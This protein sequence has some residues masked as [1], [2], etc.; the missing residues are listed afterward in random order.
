MTDKI[1]IIVPTYNRRELLRA[2]LESFEQLVCSCEFEIIV[3]DDGSTDD[4][5]KMVDG[6]I[7]SNPGLNLTYQYLEE[8][9]GPSHARN[10]G[11]SISSGNLLAF[12]DSDCRVDSLWAEQLYHFLQKNPSLGGVGGKVLP[13][14][15][16]IISR[17]YTMHKLLE[18]PHSMINLIGA[19]CMFWKQIVVLAG[20]FDESFVIPGGEEVCLC[21]KILAMGYHFGFEERAIVFHDYRKELRDFV[22]TFFNYGSG[23]RNIIERYFPLYLKFVNPPERLK[24]NIALQNHKAFLFYFFKHQLSTVIF[25]ERP[26]LKR[27]QLSLKDY[28]AFQTL[29]I[30]VNISFHLGRGTITGVFRKRFDRYVTENCID[31]PDRVNPADFIRKLR[32]SRDNIRTILSPGESMKA[33]VSFVNF[34]D[35]FYMPRGKIKIFID[36]NSPNFSISEIHLPE[37]LIFYPKMEYTCFFTLKTATIEGNYT[38][39]VILK[40]VSENTGHQLFVRNIM[41]TSHPP[42]FNAAIISSS[43][44]IALHPGEK[45]EVTIIMKNT[46]EDQW[47]E[48]S[49]VFLG[50]VDDTNNDANRFGPRYVKIPD[51]CDVLPGS[52]IEFRFII[53]APGDSGDYTLKYR[54]VRENV[55]SFGDIFECRIRVFHEG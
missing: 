34:S 51:T 6:W 13:V 7:K 37:K 24:N 9:S 45:R 36:C 29:F 46:G 39:K 12:T 33:S 5:S 54:M 50:A 1:S 20:M 48:K 2:L 43:F 40:N 16:D 4:T 11:I 38:L 31:T 32:V 21:Y 3:V 28:I 44:P 42:H 26:F 14:N 23:E 30:L 8:R 55:A 19:N 52:E 10:V 35:Q 25:Y 27:K 49:N 47:N 41:I 17:Y 53:C 22:K 18:P 15:R